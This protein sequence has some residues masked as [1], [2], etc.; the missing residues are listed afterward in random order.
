LAYEA[1]THMFPL[2]FFLRVDLGHRSDRPFFALQHV[3][4]CLI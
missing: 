1:A 2:F 3:K 4:S